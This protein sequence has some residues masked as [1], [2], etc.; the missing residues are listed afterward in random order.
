MDIILL[1]ASSIKADEWNRFIESS[2]EGM[3]YHYY[4]YLDA[5][6]KNWEAIVIRNGDTWQA[7]YPVEPRKKFGIIRYLYP[8]RFSQYRGVVFRKMDCKVSKEYDLKKEALSLIITWLDDHFHVVNDNF[9]PRFDYPLPFHWRAYKLKVKYTYQIPLMR[10]EEDIW[11][12]MAEHIRRDIRKTEKS[13]ITVTIKEEADEVID[14]FIRNKASE[15]SQLKKMDHSLLLCAFNN[16]QK[17]G[18]AFAMIAKTPGGITCAGILVFVYGNI[19]TYYFG[20]AERE[21]KRSGAMS[22]ILWEALKTANNSG[23]AVF[24]FEGSM[25]ESIERFF[26]GFGAVPV[27]YLNI[28]KKRLHL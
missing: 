27:P 14:L 28:S 16:M 6:C 1:K 25:I 10:K 17:K 19:F 8:G 20:T 15:I 24:D 7:V 21:Y 23:Y 13:G 9:S 11:A 5:V 3:I 4:E 22:L 26:R 2:E 18:N 12:D